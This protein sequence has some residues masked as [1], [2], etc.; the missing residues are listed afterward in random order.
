[1]HARL[2]PLLMKNLGTSYPLLRKVGNFAQFLNNLVPHAWGNMMKVVSFGKFIAHGCDPQK[3][4]GVFMCFFLKN[5]AVAM[6][7]NR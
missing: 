5:L 3:C 6:Q 4:G 2:K 1:M 7:R